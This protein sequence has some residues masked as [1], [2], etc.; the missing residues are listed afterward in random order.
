[1]LHVWIYFLLEWNVEACKGILQKF[2]T[3]CGSSITFI[4][5]HNDAIDPRT[6]RNSPTDA[7]YPEVAHPDPKPAGQDI[8]V[9]ENAESINVTATYAGNQ[10]IPMN[11]KPPPIISNI[12]DAPECRNG[13]GNHHHEHTDDTKKSNYVQKMYHENKFNGFIYQDIMERVKLYTI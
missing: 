9:R 2:S 12:R 1:M 5:T 7:S 10:S 6:R 3:S 8:H 4:G 13:N 11:R